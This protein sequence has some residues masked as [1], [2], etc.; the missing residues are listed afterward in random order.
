M[1]DEE[2]Y[3]ILT[4][5][6]RDVFDDDSFVLTPETSAANVPEWDSF[7]HVNILVA[8]ELKF[9]IKFKLSEINELENVRDFVDLI[10]SKLE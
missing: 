5:I 7:N 1:D 3:A 9:G 2:I 10:R 6:F 4:E 8:S